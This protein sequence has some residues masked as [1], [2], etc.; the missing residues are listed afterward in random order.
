[1]SQGELP[2][3]FRQEIALRERFAL[4]LIQGIAT[5]QQQEDGKEMA[6]GGEWVRYRGP[7]GGE[8]WENT[9]T[10]ERVY[11]KEKPGSS[12]AGDEEVAGT[13]TINVDG[14]PLRAVGLDEAGEWKDPEDVPGS[15][16][17]PSVAEEEMVRRYD[18]DNP[19][20]K[21][22]ESAKM[23]VDSRNQKYIEF[24]PEEL[25][26]VD[27][28]KVKQILSN[29]RGDDLYEGDVLLRLNERIEK[30]NEYLNRCVQP[31]VDFRVMPEEKVNVYD[32]D[33]SVEELIGFTIELYDAIID[34][35]EAGLF[36]DVTRISGANI[37]NFGFA[38]SPLGYY[39]PSTGE[40]F[41]NPENAHWDTQRD[42]YAD[43]NSTYTT[44]VGC[45]W[46]ELAHA[47][48]YQNRLDR[49]RAEG[50]NSMMLAN[51]VQDFGLGS[52]LLSPQEVDFAEKHLSEYAATDHMEFIAETVGAYKT[53]ELDLTD[54]QM[55]YVLDVFK[56][57]DG[58]TELLR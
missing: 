41:I 37:D 45:F 13:A 26:E 32:G 11:Q 48:H 50:D 16:L 57:L 24:D 36:N 1:M 38:V 28:D 58:P 54:E 14:E 42:M 34:A 49:A 51:L 44:P 3:R 22:I 39:R 23:R 20:Y 35:S 43:G 55:R 30:V 25:E 40:M 7:Q 15:A 56:F 10:G 9:V 18:I 4:E 17:P 8:G 33:A 6:A 5:M 47:R 19:R 12:S 46:H 21:T 2:E 29:I 27:R 52:S 53:G 31:H